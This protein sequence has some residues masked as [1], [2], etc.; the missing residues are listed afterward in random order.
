[1]DGT[2]LHSSSGVRCPSTFD[3]FKAKRLEHYRSGRALGNFIL[4]V[5][6]FHLSNLIVVRLHAL[7]GDVDIFT[8]K[9]GG[10]H[11][12]GTPQMLPETLPHEHI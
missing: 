8:P 9:K 5:T 6:K 7:K 2:P 4:L 1:M 11:G 10:L 3:D 12:G